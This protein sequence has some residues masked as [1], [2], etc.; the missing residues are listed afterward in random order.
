M[1]EQIPR[2]IAIPPPPPPPPPY[3]VYREVPRTRFPAF[4]PLE[5]APWGIFP[6]GPAYGNDS[7]P[8]APP[9]EPEPAAA[10]PRW[11]WIVAGVGGVVMLAAVVALAARKKQP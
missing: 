4:W 2:V 8:S 11:P 10:A 5:L 1:A 6:S 9:P 7:S 3:P